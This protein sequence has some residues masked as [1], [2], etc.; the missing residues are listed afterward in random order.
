MNS[1]EIPALDVL[2]IDDDPAALRL[3]TKFISAAG[4]R[5]AQAENGLQA[6]GLI[7][8][9]PPDLVVCD[10]DMPQMDGLELCRE[11][12]KQQLPQYVYFLLLTGKS[13]TNDLVEGL[14]AGADDF[15]SKPIDQAVLL[16]RI[17]AGSRVLKM[18][19]QLRLQSHCD[20][21]TGVLNRR[22][23]HGRFVQ[24]WERA[25]RYGHP[26]SCA[27]ID[28]DFFKRIND[29][30]GHA[31]GD[32][33]LAS[34]A[35]VLEGRCRKSDILCRYGGEEFCVLLP[36]TD[37]AGAC[38]W[39]ERVRVAISEAQ[40][41][42]GDGILKVSASIGIA[43][44]MGDTETPEQLTELADQAL[45]V[46]KQSGRN[47]V[48]RFSSL[49]EPLLE[50]SERYELAGPLDGVTAHDAMSPAMFCP[51]QDDAVRHVA[52][53]FLQLRMNSAPVVDKGGKI[54]G[55]VTE[56]DLL[57]R[58]TRGEGWQERVRDVMN[59]DVVCYEESTPLE[60]VYR[61]LARVSIPRV[62]V[63]NSGRPTGVI[64][65]ATLLRW[66]RN[67]MEAHPDTI[68]LPS[69]CSDTK[70]EC[71]KSGIIR[72]ADM[73]AQRAREIS[74]RVVQDDDFVPCVVG[75]AT[76]LQSLVNDLLGY[77]AER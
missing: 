20:P 28:L 26:L 32:T 14:A 54:A 9:E 48:I 5:V 67:W 38:E 77:C 64:S 58:T 46:A 19:R 39:A 75:E 7:L 3:I 17:E 50:L 11:I 57:T 53:I 13:A 41:G 42:I 33:T 63:V 76:K 69:E 15:L 29:T 45:A 34:I 22:A 8:E 36:E 71:R 12:R 44:R 24:E 1:I 27:M 59:K 2:V 66:F 49:G 43:E 62:V 30:H 35:S 23:F 73:A 18:E 51:T 47:R 52:D 72:T 40:I 21:L 61:F 16:A 10:W 56:S 60:Q 70:L 31:A 25:V 6:K 37:E 65:R 4:H 55:I 74:N 68:D